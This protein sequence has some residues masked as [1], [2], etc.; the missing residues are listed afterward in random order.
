MSEEKVVSIGE[1]R[2][3][4]E[5]KPEQNEENGKVEYCSFCGRHNH[6][7]LRMVLGTGVNI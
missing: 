3:K 5:H 6:K 4:K 1:K 2:G 7:C